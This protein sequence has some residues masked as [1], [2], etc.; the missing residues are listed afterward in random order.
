MHDTKVVLHAK[1][2]Q[3]SEPTILLFNYET[4]SFVFPNPMRCQY[5]YSCVEVFFMRNINFHSFVYIYSTE[6]CLSFCHD[7]NENSGFSNPSVI[8]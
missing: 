2:A 5:A 1:K 3:V 4:V 8:I 6:V 7:L